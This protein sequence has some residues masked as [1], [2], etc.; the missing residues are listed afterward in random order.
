[1]SAATGAL[2]FTLGLQANQFLNSLGV[3]S[4]KLV[5]FLG[6]A[7]GI[8]MAFH[9]MWGAIQTGGKLND[10]AASANLTVK[11]LYQLQRAFDEVGA[12]ADS[13]PAVVN[14][15]R[16]TMGSG[17]QNNLLSGIGLDPAKL[18]RMDPAK[19]F[20]AIAA[21]LSRLDVN[22]RS[23]A[24]QKLFGREGAA[25]AM[26][27]A[28]SGKDFAEAMKAAES[29]AEIW[30][31]VAKSFD[32]IGDKIVRITKRIDTMW[33]AITGALNE[34]FKRGALTE[35]LT[36]II[37]TTL[38]AGVAMAIPSF[39]KLGEVLMIA[40]QRPLLYLQA[41]LEY[42]LTIFDSLVAGQD[43]EGSIQRYMRKK[44][45]LKD[46]SD[47]NSFGEIFKN[48]MQRGLEFNFGT[49]DF[50]LTDVS[51]AVNKL[52]G[53]GAQDAG[54]LLAGLKARLLALLGSGGTT[55]A[56]GGGV[57][58]GGAAKNIDATSI[59][60]MGFIFNGRGSSA[61]YARITAENTR[62]TN[63]LLEKTNQL[64]ARNAA[65]DFSNQ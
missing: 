11:Q 26:Q 28:N 8:Q 53:E 33:A 54:G 37:G 35:I 5:G 21:S 39:L 24:A 27:I 48:R 30:S 1:M 2:N 22:A 55:N 20:E 34:A 60:K 18:G 46:D 65:G 50:G 32:E 29:D 49:G 40:L 47:P 12:S 15:L 9:K 41:S 3:A 57:P 52:F 44:A 56:G 62:R 36:D 23:N 16:R 25:T 45:G 7:N 63:T 17:E 64:L 4:G 14:K 59:E 61:D 42:A 13:V 51:A 58:F 10:L 43:L 31:R 38:Q 6:V 19:Q